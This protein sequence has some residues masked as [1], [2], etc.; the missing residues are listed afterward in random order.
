MC[1]NFGMRNR[2]L[3]AIG[4]PT[5]NN[6]FIGLLQ[7]VCLN[8]FWNLQGKKQIERGIWNGKVA[9]KDRVKEQFSHGRSFSIP[10]PSPTVSLLFFFYGVGHCYTHLHVTCRDSL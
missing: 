1:N 6:I 8:W 9:G 2:M 4:Q 5:R 7:A 10:N 3:K